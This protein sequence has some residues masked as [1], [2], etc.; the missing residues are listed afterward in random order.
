M[1]RA[2][3]SEDQAERIGGA[4]HYGFS[5]AAGAAYAAASSSL[6]TLRTGRGTVF[7]A[8]LWLVGDELAVTLSGLENPAETAAFSHASALAAHVVYGMVLEALI[9]PAVAE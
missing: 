6:P 7:G 8:M 5:I 3:L 2:R 1:G 9:E 4:M